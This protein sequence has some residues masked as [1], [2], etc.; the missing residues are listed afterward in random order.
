MKALLNAIKAQL[1][2]DLT[3]IRDSDIFITEDELAIPQSV[4]FPA[5]GIKD[6]AITYVVETQD[7][8]LD[9]LF[10][11]V[12]PYVQLQKPE[13][14][15]MGDSS[16]GKKGVLDITADAIASLKNN[17]LSGQVDVALPV[18]E[19]ESEIL[20]DEEDAIQMKILTMRYERHD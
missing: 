6:G 13:A 10:V 12:I 19:A 7:Q 16:T 5:V 17:K 20:T 4:C 11:K 9:T 14:S 1:Q 18:S 3:Y 15:I 2:T 8:D